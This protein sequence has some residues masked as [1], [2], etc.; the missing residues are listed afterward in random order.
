M[1]FDA[2]R[3]ISPIDGRYRTSTEELA[4]FFS[5]AALIKYR[6][7]VEIAYLIALKNLPLKELENLS[8]KDIANISS[9]AENLS[10]ENLNSIKNTESKINHDVKAVEYYIRGKLEE[11]GLSHINEFVH[12][13]LTSQDI[14]NTAIPLAIKDAIQKSWLPK[15]KSILDKLQELNV[16]WNDV[17]M[18]ARTHGQPASPTRMGKEIY[19]FHERTE[20]QLKL[21]NAIPYPAKFGGATGNFNAH[22]VAYPQVNWPE[23]GNEFIAS[24]GLK[25]SRFTTQIDHYDLLSAI[26]DNIKRINTI[27]IDLC[28]DCW[29]YISLDYFTQI[30]NE[31]EVG[32][33]TMPHKVNPLDF[34]NAEGNFGFAN[35]IFTHLSEKLPVSRMQRDLSDSTVMRNIGVPFAHSMVG[36]NSLLKG[37]NK[38]RL[39]RPALDRDL[40]NNWS[41]VAEGIQTVLRREGISNPYESLKALTRGKRKLDKED[42]EKYINA[43][44]ISE[45]L[46]AELRAITPFNY[47]GAR[48]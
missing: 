44:D 45:S 32:S 33:S 16:E 11:L 9:I 27:F 43:L 6:I 35:A 15:L 31:D 39:N 20:Q 23:F 10:R 26:F 48:E 8:A 13:G 25:R 21:L 18:L 5:E 38:I 46:K 17:P 24:L 1:E 19:V 42:F 2:L 22:V 29:S 30:V 40:E 28:R 7:G 41:V 34:E 4:A 12:F 37:L 3:A 36:M 14:N 47:T